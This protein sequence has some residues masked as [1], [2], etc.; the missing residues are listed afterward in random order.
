MSISDI[1]L[2]EFD[3]LGIYEEYIPQKEDNKKRFFGLYLFDFFCGV[4]LKLFC[5]KCGVTIKDKVIVCPICNIKNLW[6]VP[7]KKGFVMIVLLK[8]TNIILSIIIIKKNMGGL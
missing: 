8:S 7:K 5:H 4:C 2:K 3:D 1:V 6:F